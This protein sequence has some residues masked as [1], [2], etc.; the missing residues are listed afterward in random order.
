MEKKR[1]R[2]NLF[3]AKVDDILA[4]NEFM[5][6]DFASATAEE[7]ESMVEKH[8]SVSYWRDA[9]RRFRQ[10]HVSMVAL[11]VVL[12]ITLFAFAGPYFI[13]YSYEEQYRASMKLGPFEYSE[14]EQTVMQVLETADKVYSTDM[15]PGSLSTLKKGTY[16]FKAKGDGSR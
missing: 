6:E 10:N 9:G 3:H 7:K 1:P 11:A 14:T 13:P 16:Y 8:K 12:L 5:M 2:F 15:Q 4:E